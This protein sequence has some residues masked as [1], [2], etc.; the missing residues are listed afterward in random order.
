KEE[1]DHALFP[2]NDP[3]A[4]DKSNDT[5]TT[6]K[7]LDNSESNPEENEI[8]PSKAISRI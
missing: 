3:N 8:G 1:D 6:E 4:V 7:N 2:Q 5:I